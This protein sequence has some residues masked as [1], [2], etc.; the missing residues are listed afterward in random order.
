[1]T[2][3]QLPGLKTEDGATITFRPRAG[4]SLRAIVSECSAYRA[5]A[6]RSHVCEAVNG[7]DHQPP[8]DQGVDD[9]GEI[10]VVAGPRP[11]HGESALRGDSFVGE[12]CAQDGTERAGHGDLHDPLA[13]TTVLAPL[14][15]W[16]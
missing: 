1:V 15:P 10:P 4:T 14:R 13:A 5:T 2:G 3:V 12:C 7:L 16:S 9:I 8:I 6:L 11:E